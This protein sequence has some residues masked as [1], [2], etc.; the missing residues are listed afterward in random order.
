MC[1]SLFKAINNDVAT[2]RQGSTD[3]VNTVSSDIV[4]GT[5]SSSNLFHSITL[6]HEDLVI[7]L[8]LVAIN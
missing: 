4:T 8:I 3:N 7:I 6:Y 1:F 2:V 5:F